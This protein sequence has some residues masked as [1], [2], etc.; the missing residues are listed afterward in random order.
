MRFLHIGVDDIFEFLQRFPHDVDILN[1][2][3]NQ[4][5][6]LVL[7]ALIPSSCGL[8]TKRKKTQ[9]I[10]YYSLMGFGFADEILFLLRSDLVGHCV[11]TR[12]S[13]INGQLGG[14]ICLSD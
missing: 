8:G 12:P 3:E 6:I 13:V 4:L 1:V 14:V 11:D 9:T 7:I 5:C 2:Q 10:H